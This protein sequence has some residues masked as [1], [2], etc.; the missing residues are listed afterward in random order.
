MAEAVTLQDMGR[1]LA[2]GDP[3]GDV[4]FLVAARVPSMLPGAMGPHQAGDEMARVCIDP[5]V[6]RF[7]ADGLTR[8]ALREPTGRKFGRPASAQPVFHVTADGIV[9]KA[10]VAPGLAVAIFRALLRFVGKIVPGVNWGRVAS[11]LSRD[12][13]GIAPKDPGHLPEGS[14]PASVNREEITFVSIEM[15]VR[16]GLHPRILTRR[17]SNPS[18]VALRY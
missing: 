6:D 2:N 17:P 7:V 13:A 16:F 10:A 3:S 5:L 11:K 14:A 4:G 12:R 18:S 1:T 9:L 8:E 15:G